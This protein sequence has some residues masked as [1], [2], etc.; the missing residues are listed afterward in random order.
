MGGALKGTEHK[1]HGGFAISDEADNLIKYRYYNLLRT[2]RN[3]L[4]WGDS[5]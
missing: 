1:N 3:C 2:L 5:Y 4:I